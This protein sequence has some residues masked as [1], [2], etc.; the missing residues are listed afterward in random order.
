MLVLDPALL[1]RRQMEID[2][3]RTARFP[4]L[5]AHKS[6]RMTVSPF[7]LLRGAAP[8]FYELLER[9][10]P[11]RE[12]PAGKG[13]L[14]GDAH[15]ENFGAYRAGVLS[16]AETKQSR[17][18][19]AVV[20]DLNDF[21][22]AVVGP[23]RFDVLRLLTSLVL[24]G[25]EA[26][27]DGPRALHLCDALLDS[28]VGAA[29][30]VRRA[31]PKPESVTRLVQKVRERTRAEFLE[32]RTEIVR[33]KR[34]FVRG[35]RYGDLPP[36]LRARAERAFARY[37][38]RIA[39]TY[40]VPTEALEVIDAAFRVAGTGSLGCL[41]IAVLVAGKGGLDGNW[42]FDMKSQ[43]TASA[44]RL[45]AATDLSP[46]ERV[47]AA[48]DACLVRPPQMVDAVRLRRESMF[49][50]RLA[51]QEDKLELAELAP[52]ELEPLVRHLGSQ[53]GQ[54]H[55]RGVTRAPKEVW[56]Q[57]ERAGLLNRAVALAGA[58]E[59]MYLAYCDLLRS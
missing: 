52:S 9:H 36:K 3:A 45:V 35:A 44:A 15:L 19:E 11:L 38:K 53:L 7:A 55:R 46:A 1:A 8:L 58:H 54:A 26:G 10:P 33:G 30:H 43:G 32:A 2:R 28:Y 40:G 18:N 42:I 6:T 22:D 16:T 25:R 4:P 12:G 5:L 39:R 41:R 17:A 37:A 51:P 50:R 21:D 14:V 56:T 31:P 48:L 57:A 49:V 27:A 34:R 13:W 24:G 23:W 29:F 47:C 59:A 20:F